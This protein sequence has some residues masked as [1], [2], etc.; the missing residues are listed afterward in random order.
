MTATTT[1]TTTTVTTTTGMI[2]TME[3][4]TVRFFPSHRPLSSLFL[5]LPLT[6]LS[7]SSSSATE[8]DRRGHD[9]HDYGS[10]PL[11][12]PSPS[13]ELIFSFSQTT[14]ATTTTTT[15][16][17]GTVTATTA[18]ELDSPVPRHRWLVFRCVG[19][20]F[21]H[22]FMARPDAHSL[23]HA[24][25]LSIVPVHPP[26][27]VPPSLLSGL[28]PSSA[29]LSLWNRTLRCLSAMLFPETAERAEKP[30]ERKK[31]AG[32]RRVGEVEEGNI[33]PLLL[34]SRFSSLTE[35]S[36]FQEVV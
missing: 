30:E 10:F 18:P 33:A 32:V 29:F 9:D 2:V 20:P 4:D 21:F 12:S 13:L 16:P 15:T 17:I 26:S 11:F 22:S 23:P 24:E 31:V 34:H 14:T 28:R 25:S 8:H 19:P 6:D 5:S 35:L 27:A 7:P 36:H 3:V 1:A